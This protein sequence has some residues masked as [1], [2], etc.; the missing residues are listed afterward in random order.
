MM[1]P[2]YDGAATLRQEIEQLTRSMGEHRPGFMGESDE[3]HYQDNVFLIRDAGDWLS[4][5]FRPYDGFPGYVEVFY[6]GGICARF[7]HEYPPA[8]WVGIIRA[9]S[10]T[11]RIVRRVQKG[12]QEWIMYLN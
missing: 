2:D 8:A 5:S 4:V 10:F 6:I 11:S 9:L 7:S 1:F 12:Y 3:W